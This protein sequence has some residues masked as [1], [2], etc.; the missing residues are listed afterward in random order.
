MAALYWDLG[1]H[2]FLLDMK[3]SES[4]SLLH[5][6]MNKPTMGQLS[7]HTQLN[8]HKLALTQA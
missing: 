2:N 7:N 1:L 3:L 6:S 8:F 4:A 5:K